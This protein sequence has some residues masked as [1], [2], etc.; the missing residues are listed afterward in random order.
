MS[1]SLTVNSTW[2]FVFVAFTVGS[3]ATTGRTDKRQ[4]AERVRIIGGSSGMGLVY[5]NLS[6]GKRESYPERVKSFL[7]PPA[8]LPP[9][10]RLPGW[11]QPFRIGG[12]ELA[13][14]FTLAPLAGYTNLPFRMSV[15]DVGGVGLCTTDL[16]NA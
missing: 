1:W 11:D 8:E 15:R 5:G 10:P 12:V 4:I 3:P 2:S 16:V 7:A 13:S 14:R 6:R 9:A